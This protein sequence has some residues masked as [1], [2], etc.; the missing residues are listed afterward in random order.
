MSPGDEPNHGAPK[1]P[2]GQVSQSAA[3]HAL[4]A[5]DPRR[6][7]DAA[8]T[9]LDEDASCVWA[10]D[11]TAQA[12]LVLGCFAEA[13]K[14]AKRVIALAPNP[15]RWARFF[16]VLLRWGDFQQVLAQVCPQRRHQDLFAKGSRFGGFGAT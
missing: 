1:A 11:I 8:R 2:S 4:G 15:D 10:L 5:G 3:L 16:D 9:A 14:A 13:A 12:N 6:A 7:R